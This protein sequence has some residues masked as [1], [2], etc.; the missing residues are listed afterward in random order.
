[1]NNMVHITPWAVTRG[2]MAGAAR[3]LPAR[4]TLY[5]YGPYKIGGRHTAPSNEE[6]DAS[7]RAINPEWGVREL[8]DVEG[9]AARHGF[10]LAQTRAM[11]ANNMSILFRRNA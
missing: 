5:L 4:D 7:L 8:A 10:T 1:C 6:F 2:L 3:I 9:L 11:P